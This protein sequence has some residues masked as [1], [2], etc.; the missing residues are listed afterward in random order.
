MN[1]NVL[2]EVESLPQARARVLLATYML[3]AGLGLIY[4]VGFAPISAVHNAAHDVRHS[5]SFPC[6]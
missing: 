4:F 3:I 2:R 6:H 1:T 5:S